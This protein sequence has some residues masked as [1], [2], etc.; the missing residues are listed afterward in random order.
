M[1]SLHNSDLFR[2]FSTYPRIT[3]DKSKGLRGV[4][5]NYLKK[6]SRETNSFLWLTVCSAATDPG[7]NLVKHLL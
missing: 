7:H 6:Q 1:Q 2:L 4:A 5:Q 3:F